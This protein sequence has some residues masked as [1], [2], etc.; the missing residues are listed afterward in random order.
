VTVNQMLSR[1]QSLNVGSLASSSLSAHTED[2][3]D[4][5]REQL[6]QGRDSLDMTL[7]QYRSPTYAQMK[8]AMNSRPG[9]G[10]PDLFLTGATHRSISFEVAGQSIKTNV[11]DIHGL[12]EKYST[13]MSNPFLLSPKTKKELKDEHLQ[14]TFIQQ[15]KEILFQ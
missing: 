7:R 4:A 5:Q 8:N 12:E 14:S 9:L 11:N 6:M 3:A 10:N 1:L 15:T 13:G 2:M